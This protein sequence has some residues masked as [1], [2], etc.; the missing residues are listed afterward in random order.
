MGI[1]YDLIKKDVEELKKFHALQQSDYLASRKFDIVLNAYINAH[2]IQNMAIAVDANGRKI[3]GSHENYVNFLNQNV[4]E[5]LKGIPV[6]TIDLSKNV[7]DYEKYINE[8]EKNLTKEQIDNVIKSFNKANN[9]TFDDPS[10][11]YDEKIKDIKNEVKS[12]NNDLLS[13]DEKKEISDSLDF[14]NQTFILKNGDY[15]ID[16]VIDISSSARDKLTAKNVNQFHEKNNINL[17]GFTEFEKERGI[18]RISPSD[19]KRN[20]LLKPFLSKKLNLSDDYK[21]KILGLDKVIRD[22]NILNNI[23]NGESGSKEYGFMD[24]FIKARTVN[25]DLKKYID[26]KETD[27]AKRIEQLKNINNQTKELKALTE[28][29]NNVLGYIKENFDLNKASIPSNVY[30][31]R[32]KN[33]SDEIKDFTPDFPEIFDGNTAPYS[34]ILNGFSQIKAICNKGNITIEQFLND[35]ITEFLNI[36]KKTVKDVDDTIALPREGNT[37]GKRMA[38]VLIQKEKLY[39]PVTEMVNSTKCLEAINKTTDFDENT[40]DDM[41]KTLIASHYISQL[42]HSASLVFG[43][44]DVGT[45]NIKNLFALGDDTDNLLT[46]SSVYLDGNLDYSDVDARYNEKIKSLANVD[47]NLECTRI[48]NI[49]SDYFIERKKMYDEDINHTNDDI[50]KSGMI[51]TAAKDYFLDYLYKNNI[52]LNK[53]R[54]EQTKERLIEFRRNP[55]KTFY[56]EFDKNKDIFVQKHNESMNEY[57]KQFAETWDNEHN[58]ATTKFLDD[59]REINNQGNGYNKGKSIDGIISDNKGG[60]WERYILHSTSD[61]YKSLV[62]AINDVKDK[63]NICYGDLETVKFYAKKYLEYKLRNKSINDLG[64]TGKKRVEFCKTILKSLSDL[65]EKYEIK[66]NQPLNDITGPNLNNIHEEENNEFQ[67]QIKENIEEVQEKIKDDEEV[68]EKNDNTIEIK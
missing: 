11:I 37:L 38:H 25:E 68:I 12:F 50:F 54:E 1:L 23:I 43:G 61:E 33:A 58:K 66:V 39:I 41:S 40:L 16:R 15:Y 64:T 9:R 32:N 46:V 55:V 18:I 19:I 14:L 47:P 24:W 62:E 36:C 45:K 28:K 35:P 27:E 59:F 65:D 44:F 3:F 52:D 53:I 49:I 30:S 57:L 60:F 5:G 22:N 21:N 13:E 48:I 4:E 26:S 7:A 34:S 56:K 17:D 2:R 42:D 10:H 67:N 63:E 29:Y 6:Y 20:N 51:F 8:L 31:G